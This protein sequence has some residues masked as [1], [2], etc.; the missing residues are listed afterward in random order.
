[1]GLFC[2]DGINSSVHFIVYVGEV[3]FDEF[4]PVQENIVERS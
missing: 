4:I 3:A 1:M 2:G